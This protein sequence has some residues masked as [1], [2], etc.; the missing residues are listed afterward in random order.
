MAA[1]DFEDELPSLS[2]TTRVPRALTLIVL[3][4]I[5]VAIAGIAYMHPAVNPGSG[6]NTASALADNLPPS[7]D[8]AAVDFVT[9][10]TGWVVVSLRSGDF[11]VLHTADAAETW[12]RQLVGSA[13]LI[14]E[15]VRFFDPLRG[16]LVSLGPQSVLYQTSDGGSTWSQNSLTQGGGYIFSADFIDP[17]DG[18]LVAQGPKVGAAPAQVLLRTVDSGRTWEPLGSPVLSGDWAYRLVFADSKVGWLYSRSAGPYAYKSDDAGTTWRR[19]A[20]PAPAGGWPA[21]PAPSVLTETFFVAAHPTV[22]AGVMTTVIGVAPPN[23]RSS[24]GGVVVDYPPLKVGTFDG[25]QS[26]TYIYADISPYRY[27][28]IEYINP[29]PFVATEPENQ[30][31]LSSVDSGHSWSAVS[32]P[33]NY[34]AVGYVDAR[35]WWWIGS[36]ARATSSDAGTTWGQIQGAGVPEPLP[37]SLQFI[38][39]S[40][41]WFGAMAGTRALVEATDDG[42]IHWRMMMLPPITPS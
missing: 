35:N 21:A 38:D 17:R 1:M 14:G 32:V 11:A 22:G 34:G 6:S 31:Q 27:A 39:A 30:Y 7:Y 29:G 8:L 4:I 33:S 13:G 5:T 25:G 23:G 12:K 28:S 9:P 18:W 20:L 40:H 2:S 36:G 42:G 26:V 10:T 16:V 41:A 15:Y 19:V 24:G 3:S 37:G